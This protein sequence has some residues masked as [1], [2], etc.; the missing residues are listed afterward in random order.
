[1][2]SHAGHAA[3]VSTTRTAPALSSARRGAPFS[4]CR[5]AAIRASFDACGMDGLAQKIPI[6]TSAI[7]HDL[8]ARHGA[9]AFRNMMDM[10][11]VP[12]A[13]RNSVR[14]DAPGMRRLTDGER[15]ACA[16]GLHGSDVRSRIGYDEHPQ[17]ARGGRVRAS[18]LRFDRS[19]QR[20]ALD[21]RSPSDGFQRRRNVR[22]SRPRIH[23][24]PRSHP[25]LMACRENV[26][27]LTGI[28]AGSP[29]P[30]QDHACA[31]AGVSAVT[32]D[33]VL[34]CSFSLMRAA[35]PER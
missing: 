27:A 4:S 28:A 33:A 5:R 10:E 8:R 19:L 34:V 12:A 22:Y 35:L 26:A 2:D 17:G 11:D 31:A 15:T 29:L 6:M 24:Q 25:S 20:L 9:S 7:R 14:R 18:G 23:A 16:K 32:A 30:R 1:M 21:H 13:A 3:S